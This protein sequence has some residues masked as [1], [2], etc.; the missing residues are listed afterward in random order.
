MMSRK[1]AGA[2]SSCSGV[3]PIKFDDWCQ[4]R[5]VGV[6]RRR[7]REARGV[8]EEEQEEDVA[9][10]VVVVVIVVMRRIAEERDGEGGRGR[11]GCRRCS[12]VSSTPRHG[13]R[14]Q[15]FGL[16]GEEGSVALAQTLPRGE[17]PQGG[18]A[19]RRHGPS[20]GA[21]ASFAE[22]EGEVPA[23]GAGAGRQRRGR[24][25]RGSPAGVAAVAAREPAL[26]GGPRPAPADPRGERRGRSLRPSWTDKGPHRRP[27]RSPSSAGGSAV[28][29]SSAEAESPLDKQS[30]NSAGASAAPAKG[31]NTKRR[32][33]AS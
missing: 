22:G 2:K 16:F 3:S 31:R 33:P 14:G 32:S 25:R 17:S 23:E 9:G 5:G 4:E 7:E 11:R 12:P 18:D 10:V 13:N 27:D 24:R 6:G 26:L 28:G 19:Q 21:R 1:T 20:V 29:A 15:S 8:K 30:S